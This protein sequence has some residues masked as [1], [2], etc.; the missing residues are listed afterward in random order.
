[1]DKAGKADGRK[2]RNDKQGTWTGQR[3]KR[4]NYPC[5]TCN[6]LASIE[7]THLV[8]E[9]PMISRK[10]QI[11]QAVTGAVLLAT[12]LNTFAEQGPVI[13]KGDL[14]AIVGD[15]ITEQKLYSKYIEMYLT[16]CV[17]ELE[18][19]TIQ[20][21]WSGE[22]APGFAGRMENDLVPFKPN[23]VTTCY[24]MNDGS[25]RKWD[26]KIGVPYKNSMTQIVDR[27][28]KEGATVVVGAP[29]AVDNV[30]FRRSKEKAI[31]YNDNLAHLRDIAKAI[32]E[33]KK[34]PFAN[35][36]DTMVSAMNKAQAELGDKYHV[37]GGDG[38]HPSPNGQLVM[39]YAFL[40][41]MGL[42]G[43]LGTITVDLKG[44]ATATDGHKVVSAKDGKVDLESSRY[45]FCFFGDNKSP[46]ST[47]SI[48]P[49]LPFNQDLNRLVLKVS[50][51]EA[52]QYKVT[53][54][55]SSKDFTS[56]QLTDGIN[57]AS[58]FM[59]NPFVAPFRNVERAVAQKQSFETVMIKRILTNF[60]HVKNMFK[61]DKVI[62]ESTENIRRRMDE[63]RHEL[64]KAAQD[65]FKT[66]K[67]TITIAAVAE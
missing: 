29:G 24:G 39:A 25:Y 66:V 15:S 17:P 65:A 31:E 22:R 13:K 59:D 54:G 30:S 61:G 14:V 50:S 55:K 67:H 60:R 32:A 52:A 45:P 11:L 28:I 2:M 3:L 64:G 7:S 43:N 10:A 36:H 35:V 33:E 4:L 51:A 8:K 41:A 1:M 40:E 20:L 18:A 27:M 23:V 21:G 63:K 42:D 58:E 19:T 6:L 9:H 47:K 46:N 38:V 16:V 37:C 56:A 5:T 48:L 57:L 34:M 62:N 12:C 49:Y 53:W 26:P 44:T